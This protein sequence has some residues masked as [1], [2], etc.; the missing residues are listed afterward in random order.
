MTQNQ[1]ITSLGNNQTNYSGYEQNSENG[2]QNRDVLLTLLVQL[3]EEAKTKKFT[4]LQE[5]SSQFLDQKVDD[6][7][8]KLSRSLPNEKT[9]EEKKKKKK[10]RKRKKRQRG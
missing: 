1:G 10:K 9:Q 5:I 3:Q 7:S 8:T 4:S 2:F 6:C